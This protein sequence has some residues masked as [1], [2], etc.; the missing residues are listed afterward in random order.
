MAHGVLDLD[1]KELRYVSAGHPPMVLQ[2]KRAPPQFLPGDGFA[3]GMV[4]DA[5][6]DEQTVRLDDGDRV[7]FYSDGVPE[8]MDVKLDQITNEKM[9]AVLSASDAKPL[10]VA[11]DELF[12]A[13]RAWCTPK[14]PRDD[15]SILGCEIAAE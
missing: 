2:P 6:Y 9:L 11:V 8:A 12:Q 10:A 7:Y 1:T 14:G 5:E 15:V 4:A 3:I 13:V